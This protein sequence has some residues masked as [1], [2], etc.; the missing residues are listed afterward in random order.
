MIKPVEMQESGFLPTPSGPDCLPEEPPLNSGTVRES[1]GIPWE[2]DRSRGA[3][4][5][6]G[7]TWTMA[8]FSPRRFFRFLREPAE[9]WAAPLIYAVLLGTAGAILGLPGTYL[10][11]NLWWADLGL[12]T[13]G[14]SWDVVVA[15]LI[16]V[17]FFSMFKVLMIGGAF[18]LLARGA[19]GKQG[20][21]NTLRVVAYAES[22][23]VF[24][25]IP[26]LGGPAANLY[27]LILY[28]FGLREAQGLTAA[29]A[30]IVI[31]APILFIG[32][33]GVAAIG[34]LGSL[35]MVFE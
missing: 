8:V 19:G 20:F 14:F 2:R 24:Q 16:T 31:A 33:A 4:R 22:L 32:L 15:I 27:R 18:H 6:L 28:F 10:F 34:I 35:G 23:E 9:G 26:S 12:G 7:E 30:V 25:V 17:P 13:G 29:R 1:Q 3:V 5:S 11:G 21:G